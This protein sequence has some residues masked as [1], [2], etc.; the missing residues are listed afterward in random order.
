MISEESSSRDVLGQALKVKRTAIWEA[1]RYSKQKTRF[2]GYENLKARKKNVKSRP[3]R[4]HLTPVR[5]AIIS[6]T[7]NNRCWR[8][9]REKEPSH[10][11]GGNV[12]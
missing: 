4:F 7:T 1:G 6:K 9:C 10:T 12:N 5:I 3:L 11:A 8:G 2:E